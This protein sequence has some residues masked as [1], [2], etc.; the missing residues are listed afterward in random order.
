MSFVSLRSTIANPVKVVTSITIAH[1]GGKNLNQRYRPREAKRE[2][3]GLPETLSM[4]QYEK[5]TA[6]VST[7]LE[8]SLKRYILE[9]G[10]SRLIRELILEALSHRQ[11]IE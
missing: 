3:Q 11:G 4:L 9:H 10:G 7:K 8:P 1:C 2:G 6:T 5:R